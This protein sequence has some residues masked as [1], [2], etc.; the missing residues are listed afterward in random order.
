MHFIFKKRSGRQNYYS[1][2]ETFK[3]VNA[4]FFQFLNF[5]FTNYIKKIGVQEGFF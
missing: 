5:F 2:R 1:K 4:D 3:N